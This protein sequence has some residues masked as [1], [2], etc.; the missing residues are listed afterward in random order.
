MTARNLEMHNFEC[1]GKN[2]ITVK[3]RKL[4]SKFYHFFCSF[5]LVVFSFY[6]ELVNKT[7]Q[8]VLAA[9]KSRRGEVDYGVQEAAG[10]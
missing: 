7:I 10:T 6:Q 1:P 5:I 3:V 9:N 8:E 4:K 2:K